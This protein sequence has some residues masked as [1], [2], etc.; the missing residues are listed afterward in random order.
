MKVEDIMTKQVFSVD[1][2]A[3]I[4]EVAGI[5]TKNRF[6]GIPVVDKN[7]YVVGIVTRDSFFSKSSV[8]LHL[9]SYINFLKDMSMKRKIS[10]EQKENV[11]KLLNTRAKDIMTPDCLCFF[12]ETDMEEAIDT[13]R[14]KKLNTFPV[15]NKNRQLVGIITL[16]DVIGLL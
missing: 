4:N 3:K 10:G 5:M 13:F 1:P 6:H 14:E 11:E 15:I 2:E 7:N 16:A 8:E 12:P 9:P